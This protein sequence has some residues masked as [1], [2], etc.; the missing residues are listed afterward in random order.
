MIIIKI[1]NA[2]E[3]IAREKSWL[4][5]QFAPY[6]IDLQARVDQAIAEEIK[7]SLQE[8]NIQAEV[9]VVKDE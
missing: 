8:Q 5:A 4:V 7:K 3:I 6:F 1:K 2:R 9:S